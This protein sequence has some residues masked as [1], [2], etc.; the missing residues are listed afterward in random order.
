MSVSVRGLAMA[1]V[2]Y[3]RLLHGAVVTG[4]SMLMLVAASTFMSASAAPAPAGRMVQLVNA[5]RA[6]A[7]CEPLQVDPGLS[8]AAQRHAADMASGDY[9]AHTSPDGA[10]MRSRFAEA[11]VSGARA[12]N[13]AWG[14]AGDPD[15]VVAALMDSSSHRDNMLDCGFTRTGAGYDGRNGARWVQMFAG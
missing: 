5:E 8:R 9:F 3:R 1:A 4:A 14:N 7:G 10:T 11:E 12:E 13:I 6:E 15:A 2:R